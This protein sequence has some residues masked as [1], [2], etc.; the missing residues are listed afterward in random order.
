MLFIRTWII[1]RSYLMMIVIRFLQHKLTPELKIRGYFLWLP[2]FIVK[3]EKAFIVLVHSFQIWAAVFHLRKWTKVYWENNFRKDN[4]NHITTD[5]W[6]KNIIEI[7]IKKNEIFH[8]YYFLYS[9][10]EEL[11]YYF[12]IDMHVLSHLKYFVHLTQ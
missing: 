8:F 2:T 4:E 1:R 9:N 11:N 10:F 12:F 7:I 3:I 6:L 5:N